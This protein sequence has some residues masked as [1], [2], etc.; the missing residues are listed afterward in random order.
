MEEK[1]IKINKFT[2]FIIICVIIAL[3]AVWIINSFKVDSKRKEEEKINKVLIN[4]GYE[5][6]ANFQ[7]YTKVTSGMTEEEYDE[8]DASEK[9][10]EILR[11]NLEKM[12]LEKQVQQ[13]I[14]NV[15]ILYL[16]TY[17]QSE[18]EGS[19]LYDY[20]LN[21]KF[22]IQKGQYDLNKED[23]KCTTIN[24]TLKN[25]TDFCDVMKKD[26]I[27]LKDKMSEIIQKK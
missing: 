9:K 19:A 1:E 18:N 23:Y 12:I 22:I 17:S 3:I 10:S 11:F 24:D 27:E 16:L 26:L 14:N 21:D 6:I 25:Q 2:I 20:S 15:E 7:I 8:S 4:S 5:E 13:K